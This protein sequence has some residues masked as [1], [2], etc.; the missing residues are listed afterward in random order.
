MERTIIY[1]LRHP[2]FAGGIADATKGLPSVFNFPCYYSTK[3]GA[4]VRADLRL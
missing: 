4:V 1:G 2:A 3:G